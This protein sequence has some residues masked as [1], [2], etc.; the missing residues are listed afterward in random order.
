MLFVLFGY[1]LA[2]KRVWGLKTQPEIWSTAL[3]ELLG[4]QLL[5]RNFDFKNSLKVLYGCEE[6]GSANKSGRPQNL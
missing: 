2:G 4:Q 3:G 5:T 6:K 1:L